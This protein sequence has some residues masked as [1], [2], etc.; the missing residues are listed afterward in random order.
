LKKRRQKEKPAVTVTPSQ[1]DVDDRGHTFLDTEELGDYAFLQHLNAKQLGK[2]VVKL[3]NQSKEQS[4]K[5]KATANLDSD[6]LSDEDGLSHAVSHALDNSGSVE[7]KWEDEEQTYE[8][9]PRKG[10]SEW[11]KQESTRLPIR[12]SK[13]KL[14]PAEDSSS[15]SG[16]ESESDSEVEESDSDDEVNVEEVQDDSG[17]EEPPN[18]GPEV[19]IGAKEA[20][21]KVAE[22][23]AE[24][25]EEKVL[26]SFLSLRFLILRL[27]ISSC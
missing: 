11:R 7:G 13:G 25:P 16:L 15:R 17:T 27:Q 26:S 9:E 24:A 1:P 5:P 12:T 14:L 8:L 6:N 23:I 4:V 19:V 20:L 21:A 3:T 22:E 10:G 18:D 2:Q